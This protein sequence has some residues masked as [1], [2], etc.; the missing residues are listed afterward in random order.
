MKKPTLKA[1]LA[2]FFSSIRE[3]FVFPSIDDVE[4]TQDEIMEQLVYKK[5]E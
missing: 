3:Q 1:K 2:F 4:I 5:Y